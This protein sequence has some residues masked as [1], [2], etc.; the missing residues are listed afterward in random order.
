M[1]KPP[2]KKMEVADRF[3]PERVATFERPQEN[4]D[5]III[6]TAG[7]ADFHLDAGTLKV[8]AEVLGLPSIVN[9]K[10]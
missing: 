5:T 4:N 10:S 3:S 7:A 2:F 1:S 6:N 9:R 8:V